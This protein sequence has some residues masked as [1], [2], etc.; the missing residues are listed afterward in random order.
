MAKLCTEKMGSGMSLNMRL[1]PS[2]LK[3]EK[4]R[5]TVIDLLLG[6]FEKEGMHVQFNVVD[7]STLKAAQKH[8][9]NYQ[10]LVV[11]VSG[12]NAYFVNLDL[13]LQ[14]DILDR[15]QFETI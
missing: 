12:Y 15:I 13:G 6:Y 7:Q 1:L 3:T 11:R 14:N 10:D 2:L 8:T 4:G 5:R 9:E